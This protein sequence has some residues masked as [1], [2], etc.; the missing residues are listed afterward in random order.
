MPPRPPKSSANSEVGNAFSLPNSKFSLPSSLTP[1]L[2]FPEFR[3]GPGWEERRLR[4]VCELNPPHSGLPDTFFYIDL[5]AVE[6]GTLKAKTLITKNEAPSRAQRLLEI[7]DVIFQIVR[8]YQRNNLFFSF[9]DTH[10]FV[11]STGYAQL[12]SH[13]SAAF[14]YHAIHTDHFVSRVMAQCIGSSYPA[15]NSSDL[16]EISLAAPSPVEQQKIAE[17][18]STLDELIGAESQKLD[19]LKAHKK[20]LMQ[21]L[22]PREGETLP[23]LRFPEFQS[24]SEWKELRFKEV[25]ARSFYGTS[26]ST[27]ETGEYPVLRMGNMSDGKLDFS[28]LVYLDLDAA[29]FEKLQLRKGDILLN[30][31][32]SYDLVGKISLFDSD[33]KCITA[34]YIVTYRLKSELVVPR[35]CNYLLN[36]GD[37][38]IR[39]KVFATRAVS[40]ANINPTTF[41]ESLAIVLP[42][43]L[44]EQHRI[45]TCL[46]SLDDLIAAQSD[47]I[48]ALKT[49]K[50]GLMQQLFPTQENQ[51]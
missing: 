20:G 44:A 42:P 39:I 51:P 33:V 15:I 11:A 24:A 2:R 17:C 46:S 38:Q 14:L 29:E 8:P 13:E 1:K 47:K 16:A 5:E 36:T 37:Y 25:V 22:F 12:R 19:A 48:E 23:R 50:Q 28:N 18:L 7:G 4:E 40:Q 34:S 31:T 43:T 32:N 45:A 21:Q 3:D 35:F 30:R 9:R 27:S 26:D 49:H 41:Q 10:P 6:R